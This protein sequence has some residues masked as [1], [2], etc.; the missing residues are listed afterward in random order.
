MHYLDNK[1]V[2]KKFTLCLSLP[3]LGSKVTVDGDCSHEIKR[4]LLCGR[5]AM[6]NPV[7]VKVAQSC[8][9]LCDPMDYIVHGILQAG[10]LEWVA[11]PF[12]SRSSWPRNQTGVS[13]IADGFFTNWAN[14]KPRQHIKK[15]RHH[16][17]DK[18][19]H[20]Q[21]CGFSSSHVWMWDSDHK[22]GWVLKNW[23]FQIVV[24]EKTLESPLNCKEIK[25]VNP[26]GNQPW[27]FIGRTDAEAPILWPPDVNSWPI[28]K[29][30]WCWERL[31]AK[32]EGGSKGWDG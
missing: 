15:Q 25:L 10:M 16:F 30:P 4:R 31:K 17:A 9:T 27:I 3:F 19:L 22:E 5:K 11:F 14:D 12:S 21:S 6:T 7:K 28:G 1:N 18:D 20:S 8:L 13:C 23:C 2:F 26:K 24:L 29:K 32:R